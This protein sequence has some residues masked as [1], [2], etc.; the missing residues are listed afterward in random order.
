LSRL[1]V[2][3]QRYGAD[4]SGGAELHARYIAER[5]SSR[6]DVRV[7]TTCARDYVTWRNEFPPG[8]ETINGIVVERFPVARERNLQEFGVLSRRVFVR[9]HTLQE[10]LEWLDS[11]GPISPAL[12][13]RLRRSGDEFEF[14]LL[15]CMRY[16]QTY[17][18]A[19]AMH[20]RAILIPTAEREP[21]LGVSLFQ[22]V[23]RGV[24]AIMY[25]SPEE[26]AA[27]QAVAHNDSVPGVVVGVGSEIPGAVDPAGARE[28]F[29]L[30]RPFL[31]Y[32]GR[33]DENKGCAELF[34]FFQQ[35]MA[36]S[37]PVVDLVL[38]GT[39][40]MAIPEHP[41]IRHL[42][43]V[44]DRDKFDLL[45]AA[46][47][48]VMPSLYESLSMVALEAWAL[49]RPVLA[50]ARC[51]VL[52]GQCHRSGAGLAYA[53][54]GDFEV[55]VRRL[56]DEPS[57]GA[58]LGRR[59]RDYYEAQYSWSVVENKYL[60]MFDRLRSSPSATVM[61]PLPGW[62]ARR[63]PDRPPAI[64]VVAALPEGPAEATV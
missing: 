43:Y 49:R 59:G 50:N 24:R 21:A 8:T 7:L 45:A 18:G 62:F 23:F 38:V 63:R 55:M 11:Q 64:D 61:E 51:D 36:T 40:A 3:V 39:A 13:S 15:F 4:I 30:T 35:Y 2:V 20:D 29:R 33:I 28:K 41:R 37:P 47:A 46:A 19:R 26:R 60:D 14:V 58:D 12:L 31:L 27:I 5:L 54:F 10:E 1:A 57:L 53:H 25:N 6:F 42:G 22:P 48:L 16:H 32:V 9:S 52:A 17:Y 34:D 56:L 44:S